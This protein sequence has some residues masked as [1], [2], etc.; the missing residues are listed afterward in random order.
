M[1]KGKFEFKFPFE[2][3]WEDLRMQGTAPNGV[4]WYIFDSCVVRDPEER[5]AIDR[6]L[7]EIMAQIEREQFIRDMDA[8]EAAGGP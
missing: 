8:A 6:N 1:G 3:P 4:K 2:P 5:A 7:G